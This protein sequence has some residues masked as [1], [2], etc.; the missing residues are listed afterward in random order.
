MD[1]RVLNESTVAS[2]TNYHIAFSPHLQTNSG[3]KTESLNA[4][5]V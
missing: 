2:E 1:V 3:W 4:M 5:G